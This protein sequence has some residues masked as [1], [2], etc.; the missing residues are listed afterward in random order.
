MI[1]IPHKI[2]SKVNF[3]IGDIFN[4][5]NKPLP[6]FNNLIID[7]MSNLSINLLLRKEIREFPDVATFAFWCRKS[8]IKRI[9]LKN[10]TNQ[11]RVGLGLLFHN[12]PSN[13]PVNFAY[14][15]AFG[16]LTGNVSI[17]RVSS[18]DSKSR[19]IIIDELLKLVNKQ[20]YQRIKKLIHVIQYDRNDEINKFWMSIV[21]G[22]LIWG[23]DETVA[24]MRGYKCKPRSREI[25][26][27]DRYSMCV[28]DS[29]SIVEASDNQINKLCENLFNDIY[30]MNQMAC[31]SPQLFNWVGLKKDFNKAKKRLW[32]LLINFA[33]S[34][35][36]FEPV[37][38]MNK[39]VDACKTAIL[40]DNVKSINLNNNLLYN[41]E[42][43]SLSDHQ[44]NLRSYYGTINEISVKNLDELSLIV[45]EKFQTLTYYGFKINE[46]KNFIVRNKLR[47]ID[48]V[49]PVGKSLDMD[50]I[51]DGYDIINHLSRNIVLS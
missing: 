3:L 24:V 16:M 29:K 32:P 22:R 4:V 50:V 1:H 42:L 20:K 36:N 25:V 35:I 51:W 44:K 10:Q 5:S 2:H 47:G 23:G 12:S 30:I 11:L 6:I 19:S 37:E 33:K 39:Y 7:Y 46:L 43:S 45:D 34:K 41:L 40:N 27:P 48:R 38:I 14:S 9:S 18:K 49:V 28:L 13:V 21:D 26:F 31:S 15:L 17:V 8:N